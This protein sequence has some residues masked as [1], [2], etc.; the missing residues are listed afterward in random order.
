[1][2]VV[3]NYAAFGVDNKMMLGIVAGMLVF[4]LVVA[5]LSILKRCPSCKSY[6]ISHKI[7]KRFQ[8]NK[9][10]KFF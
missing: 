1:M 5:V 10:G 6:N 3:I 7:H 2:F 8:C 4:A 9:C